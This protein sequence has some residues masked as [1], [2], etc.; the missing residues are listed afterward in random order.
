MA[1]Q[2]K[3]NLNEGINLDV[4]TLRMPANAAVFI[5]NLTDNININ[6][7]APALSGQDSKVRTPL[8]G[9]AA[10]SISLPSGTNYCC[11]F[12]SSEQSNE[13]YFFV[14]NNANNHSVYVIDGNTGSLTL[15]HRNSL[16]PLTDDPQHFMNEGRVTLELRSYVDP[17]TLEES[18][19]KFLIFTNNTVT[20]YLIEVTSS[21]AT[22][23]FTTSYFTTSSAYYN[24]LELISLGVPTP[25]K[26]MSVTPVTPVSG[27]LLLQNLL[28]RNGWQFR[29]KFIDIFGRESEHGIISSQY[30]TIVGGGCVSLSNGL[31]RCV[32]LQFD[33][34][35]PL[36]NQIQVEFRQWIG[37]DRAGAL[38]SGWAIYETINKYQN[39]PSTPWYSRSLNPDLDFSGGSNTIKYKFCADKGD[40]PI[41]STE[42]SRTEPEIP[43]V[44]GSVFS[45][46]K[47]I[48]LAN[49]VRGFEPIDPAQIAKVSFN[50]ITPDV[51]SVCPPAPTC[52]IQVFAEIYAPFFSKIGIVRLRGGLPC[53]GIA[54]DDQN[55]PFNYDQNFVG[56]Q[57]GFSGYLVGFPAA[58]VSQQVDFNPADGS[59]T[60]N[61]T[62]SGGFAYTPMQLFEFTG[63]PEGEWIFRIAS[64]KVTINTSDLQLSSTYVCGLTFI[65]HVA[66]PVVGGISA[67]ETDFSTNPLKEIKINACSIS[68]GDVIT[69]NGY[70]APYNT[71]ATTPVLVIMDLTHPNGALA[72]STQSAIAMDGYFIEDNLDNNAIEMLPVNAYGLSSFG[73]AQDTWG[74][75]LTDHNGFYFCTTEVRF[76]A[77]IEDATEVYLQ[78]NTDT[79]TGTTLLFSATSSNRGI[80]HGNGSGSCGS[81]DSHVQGCWSNKIYSVP[82]GNSFP[83]CGRRYISGSINLC[84]SSIGV[85]GV[86]VVATKGSLTYTNGAGGYELILHNRYNIQTWYAA[87]GNHMIHFTNVPDYSASPA[88]Q[89]VLIVITRGTCTLASCSGCTFCLGEQTITYQACVTPDCTTPYMCEGSPPSTCVS[90]RIQVIPTY[91]A[92]I[93]GVNIQ[94]IQ[95]GGRYPVGFILHDYLGRHTFVQAGQN[96][97]GYVDIPPLLSYQAFLLCKIG[98]TIDP[99]VVFPSYFTK[100]TMV[101]A[102]N[103]NFSDFF[104]WTCDYIQKVDYTGQTNNVNP[105]QIR[106]YYGSNNEYQK[107]YNFSTNVGW[108]FL[109]NPPSP[110]SPA[111]IEGDLIEFIMN[112]DGTWFTERIICQVTYDSAGSF[113]TIDYQGELSNLQQFALFKV[114]RPIQNQP[115]YFTYYEQCLTI[116]LVNGVPTMFSG[117]LPYYDSYMLGRIL[118]IPLGAGLSNLADTNFTY[119]NVLD[120]L[121]VIGNPIV[122]YAG[123][124]NNKNG[125]IVM[126][127]ATAT[128]ADIFRDFS[129][130]FE[131]PSP[132]DTWGSHIANRGRI[133]TINPY[134]AQQRTGTEVALSDAL[135][136]R[137][138]LNGLSYFES[139]NVQIFDRNT[140]GDIYSVLVEVGVMMVICNNDYFLTRYNQSNLQILPDG[141]VVG[142][143]PQGEI[144]TAPQSKVGSNYGITPMYLNTLQRYNGRVVWLDPKGHLIFSDFNDS[145]P[146]EKDGYL[147]YLLNKIATNN[148]NNLIVYAGTWYFAGG[149][150]PKTMEYFL[151]SFSFPSD[152]E[153]SYINTESQPNLNVNETLIFDLSTGKL[154]SFAS[155][156]PE[157]YGRIPGYFSQKQFLS[158]KQGVPYLH[159]GNFNSITTPPP[160]ANFYGTQCE[161]RITHVINNADK[162][163]L[164]DKVKR[165]LYNEIYCRASIPGGTGVMPSALFFADTITS[166]K[167]QQSRL[168]VARWDLKDGYSC[169]AYLCDINTPYDPNMPAPTSVNAIL[170]GNPLQGRWLQ[171]SLVSNVAYSG[172]YFELSEIVNYFNMLEKS[173][174]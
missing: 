52:T 155:F 79:C 53:F 95:S 88:N 159:H 97:A 9:N 47:R 43:R 152:T 167:G 163:E 168:L 37:D 143:N 96:E 40:T 44:S 117:T 161:V 144:F 39:A 56:G 154:K 90:C 15:V 72:G 166:E 82:P 16:L 86:P 74:S 85:G 66:N 136:D 51:S 173:A 160:Y 92:S 137:G 141:Q 169:A 57:V 3:N 91:Y 81:T 124:N 76:V 5:K 127:A 71:P 145:K 93:N 25:L 108:Q 147:G 139:K 65:N 30:I 101:V 35:N 80:K 23:S 41:S 75:Y 99:S 10:L 138:I 70:T 21:I 142:Q 58:V 102:P 14:W 46:N 78:L 100:M 112:G 20:Q 73:G 174:T 61:P 115:E 64:H 22:N 120:Q 105:A 31:P 34:G 50:A 107:E 17:V 26:C 157:M 104:C 32:I 77:G 59:W 110:A 67:L 49:N 69:L 158:F 114:I 8:E 24:P 84:A 131:S 7:G 121:N 172:T 123:L 113:I 153:P 38:Q 122:S 126:S 133:F 171:V 18:N 62:G 135:G 13:G 165:F 28:I 98:F 29:V 45:I 11:G 48:G 118:P 94:G 140:W 125:V 130:L 60:P 116:P 36:V 83:D 132:A 128:Q 146:V 106:I 149:I 68:Q 42:T 150:D 164:P 170:D 55:N 162:G 63:V 27:D 54:D 151:T 148:I 129:Y 134:E 2:F 6:Q 87:F 19:Y 119:T 156:T 89:D 4:D 103:A 109:T 33:C 12:Y 1:Y 111:P